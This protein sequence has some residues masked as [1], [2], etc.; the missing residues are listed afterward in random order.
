MKV[1]RRLTKEL[2]TG[3]E[4]TIPATAED[5][6]FKLVRC[7]FCGRQNLKAASVRANTRAF[8]GFDHEATLPKHRARASV[9]Q[10]LHAVLG[11]E[12]G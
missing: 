8:A 4:R 10:P 1:I 5:A 2:C 3:S 7:P 9:G 12:R 6:Q 11:E